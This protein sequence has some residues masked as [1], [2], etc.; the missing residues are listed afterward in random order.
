MT[1][2]VKETQEVKRIWATGRRK[3]STARV[4]LIY[5][6]SGKIII[7]KRPF[8]NYFSWPIHRTY[9]LEPLER[10]G[11]KDKVDIRVKVEGGGISGQ[12]GAVR[13]GIS[14]ALVELNPELRSILRKEGFLTRDPR[15]KERKKY[16]RRG[17]RRAFQWTK[18]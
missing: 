17:A 7:N 6:G 5:Q 2:E 14:R 9:I 16:G 1:Q 12:A 3:T 10:T 13:L 11:Y 18:R 4:E 8:E 15:A